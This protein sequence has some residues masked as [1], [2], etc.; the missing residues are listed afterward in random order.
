MPHPLGLSVD[1]GAKPMLS[2]EQLDVIADAYIPAL[3]VGSL[4]LLAKRQAANGFHAAAPDIVYLFSAIATVYT[5]MFADRALKLWPYFHL[6]YSTHTAL[7][8]VLVVFLAAAG[9]HMLAGT[10]VSMLAYIMLMIYQGYHSIADIV[11]T[12]MVL[13]P[14]ILWLKTTGSD[15]L[16]RRW[17]LQKDAPL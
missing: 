15:R 12:S 7:A 1:S 4:L 17:L 9:T 2:Y 14:V 5:L 8:L 3:A 10:A 11:T 16:C 13:M 6:D